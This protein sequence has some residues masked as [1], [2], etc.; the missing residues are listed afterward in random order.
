[1]PGDLV[2][3]MFFEVLCGM[4]EEPVGLEVLELEAPR[5]GAGSGRRVGVA[6]VGFET[7]S[8]V[9]ALFGGLRNLKAVG[10]AEVFITESRICED[11]QI[12][13]VL[14]ERG[15]DGVYYILPR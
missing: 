5:E 12:D 15:G 9:R 7:G 14:G 8:L 2:E 6:V 11:K 13:E 4:V 1:M 3:D 10:F